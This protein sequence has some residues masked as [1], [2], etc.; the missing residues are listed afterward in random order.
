MAFIATMGI[1]KKS[2]YS[3]KENS[4]FHHL[5]IHAGLPQLM[6]PDCQIGQDT[7]RS[8]VV[9]LTMT[10]PDQGTKRSLAPSQRRE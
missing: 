8:G 5:F 10:K 4:Q 3:V 9:Q 2:R 7:L 1:R 6:L